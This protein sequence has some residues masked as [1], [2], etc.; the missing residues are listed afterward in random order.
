MD[1]VVIVES[2]SKSKTISSYLGKGYVVLSSKGH[3]CD[4]ATSGKDGLGIDIENDFI[5]F[6]YDYIY[7]ELH[8]HW[9][10]V[11][12]NRKLLCEFDF[13]GLIIVFPDDLYEYV[14][15]SNVIK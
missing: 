5:V 14:V 7:P 6:G 2:P 12:E 9:R 10:Y 3:I 13:N 1:K 4:L 11:V 15:G 8:E